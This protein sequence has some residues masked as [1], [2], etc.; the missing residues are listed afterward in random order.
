MVTGELSGRVAIV[1]GATRGI[2]KAAAARLAAAGA[3]V[4][5]TG[6]D[7]ASGHAAQAEI[8]ASGGTAR[9]I[10]ADQQ[11]ESDW[12]RV[13]ATTTE[14][15]GPLDIL[16]ANAGIA[17]AKPLAALSLAEFG[18][19]NR[20]NLLGPFLGLKHGVA[21]MRA[22]AKGGAIVFVSSIVGKVGVPGHVHYAAAKGGLRMMAKAAALELGPESI[23]VNAV[24]PGLVRTDMTRDFDE[25]AFGAMIPLGR[26]GAPEDVA[27]AI[28]YLVSDRGAFVTGTELLV[29]G[30]WCV[31]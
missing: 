23:R 25:G 4:V 13:V 5:I 20:V 12:A 21:A 18:G 16:V 9:F 7:A 19:L 22:A 24:L 30:G 15:F 6:R 11:S 29:D 17:A 28:L 1:T 10:A 31:Q 2:G 26:F 3:R 8:A 14:T 27:N